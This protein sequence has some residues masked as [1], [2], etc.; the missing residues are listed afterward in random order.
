MGYWLF[1]VSFSVLKK[2][3]SKAGPQHPGLGWN[4][5]SIHRQWKSSFSRVPKS[6]GVLLDLQGP[7]P[8]PAPSTVLSPRTSS[9]GGDGRKGWRGCREPLPACSP[10][11]RR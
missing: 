11:S 2:K 8:H 1:C 10:L 3:R 6:H 9:A 4:E 7:D 5:Q